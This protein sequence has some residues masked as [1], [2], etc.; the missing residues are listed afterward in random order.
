M[1]EAA[2][3]HSH[4]FFCVIERADEPDEDGEAESRPD[5]VQLTL[6][7]GDTAVAARV[8]DRSCV[9]PL[10]TFDVG[11]EERFEVVL[12]GHGAGRGAALRPLGAVGEG[13]PVRSRVTV[14]LRNETAKLTVV[15]EPVRAH[16]HEVPLLPDSRTACLA[17][18]VL[19][20]FPILASGLGLS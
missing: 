2:V 20:V 16:K 12:T 17:L 18:A 15:A 1:S 11:L 3:P 13:V 9:A 14:H 7:W 5:A 10:A 19:F 6:F 4:D 8:F